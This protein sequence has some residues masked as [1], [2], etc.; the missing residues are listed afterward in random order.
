MVVCVTVVENGAPDKGMGETAILYLSTADPT[1]ASH[2][3]VTMDELLPF[4][5]LAIPML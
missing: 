3:S 5:K 2:C 4:W 1:G